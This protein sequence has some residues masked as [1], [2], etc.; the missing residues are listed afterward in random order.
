MAESGKDRSAK[1]EIKEG[2]AKA[3]KE[4]APK[5]RTGPGAK[6]SDQV[7]RGMDEAGSGAATDGGSPSGETPKKP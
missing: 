1:D 5:A 7:A 6:G 3:G 2:M 4:T